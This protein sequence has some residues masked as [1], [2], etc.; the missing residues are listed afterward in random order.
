M[1][2]CVPAPLFPAVHLRTVAP[3]NLTLLKVWAYLCT[4]M[5]L[6]VCPYAD[7]S[8]GNFRDYQE[9]KVQEQVQKLEVGKVSPT[10]TVTPT[11]YIIP[12]VYVG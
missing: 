6:T 9:V 3:S 10:I 11:H 1:L 5:P 2:K 4:C 12:S 7:E 8:A